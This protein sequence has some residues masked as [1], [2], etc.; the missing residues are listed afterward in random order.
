MNRIS[1]MAASIRCRLSAGGVAVDALKDKASR[2]NIKGRIAEFQ[3]DCSNHTKRP[4]PGL[5]FI[6]LGLG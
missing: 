5:K 6:I 1:G 2:I 4:Q 3:A